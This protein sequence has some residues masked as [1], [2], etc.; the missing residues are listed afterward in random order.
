MPWIQTVSQA[1]CNK[2]FL[3][4]GHMGPPKCTCGQ[5]RTELVTATLRGR[6]AEGE[7]ES[8]EWY[9]P[10]QAYWFYCW[11]CH[12]A[13]WPHD[14]RSRNGSSKPGPHRPTFS[15]RVG[16]CR[17]LYMHVGSS[18]LAEGSCFPEGTCLGTFFGELGL[19]R[20]GVSQKGWVWTHAFGDF[21]GHCEALGAVLRSPWEALGG[22]LD[23][24][25]SS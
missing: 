21:G 2:H 13:L 6:W 20:G 11:R 10:K 4:V 19:Q 24:E 25:I 15:S 1:V 22:P 8:W 7:G 16:A 14:H 23:E 12:L 17:G 5:K 9:T 18:G 3:R